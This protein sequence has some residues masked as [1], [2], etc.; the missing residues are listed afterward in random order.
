MLPGLVLMIK[1]KSFLLLL[2]AYSISQGVSGMYGAIMAANLKTFGVNGEYLRYTF[3]SLPPPPFLF[4]NL[5]V[6]VLLPP[7]TTEKS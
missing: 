1:N 4:V 6:W 3:K 2:L 7:L 5:E